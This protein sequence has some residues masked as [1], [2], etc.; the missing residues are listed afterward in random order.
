MARFVQTY[1]G[2]F[3]DGCGVIDSFGLSFDG[4]FSVNVTPQGVDIAEL[5][6]DE[7]KRMVQACIAHLTACGEWP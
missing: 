2:K 5:S 4:D 6:A 1:G 3:D 7:L